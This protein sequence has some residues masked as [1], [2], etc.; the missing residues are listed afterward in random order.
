M[1]TPNKLQKYV[2][3]NLKKLKTEKYPIIPEDFDTILMT[4]DR[5]RQK[6]NKIIE[7]NKAINQQGPTD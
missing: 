3:Q 4:T 6:T 1:Y 2:N 7:L 5:T